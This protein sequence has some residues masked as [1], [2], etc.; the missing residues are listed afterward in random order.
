MASVQFDFHDLVMIPLTPIHVGGGDEAV[1][2]LEDYRVKD[3]FLERVDILKHILAAP[4]S[5][6]LLRDLERDMDGTFS[7]L[8]NR[9][10]D[11][12]VT[13]RIS[14]SKEVRKE[15]KPPSNASKGHRQGK[16]Y[17]FLRSGGFPTLPGSSLK[18]CL[19]TAWLASCAKKQELNESDIGLGKSGDQSKRLT[20]KAFEMDER[21]TAQD[22]FRDVV[23]NDARLPENATRVDMVS[24]WKF[25]RSRK[26]YEVDPSGKIQLMRERMLAVTDGGVPPLL[27]LRIGLRSA[28]VRTRRRETARKNIDPKRSPRSIFELL[29]ALNEHHAPLWEREM[30]KFF[31]GKDQRLI[32]AHRLFDRI[33]LGGDRPGG[34]LIRIG[35]SAHAEAKSVAGFRKIH[36]SQPRFR[37]KHGEF[38]KEGSTRHVI[39][40][41]GGPSPFGWAVLVQTHVWQDRKNAISWLPRHQSPGSSQGPNHRFREGDRVE[42]TDGSIATLLEG[43][44]AGKT[45]V[46]VE[47][48]G[49]REPVKISEIKG[50]A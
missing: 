5:E 27:P 46:N 30:Q 48:D 49:D 47:I 23:V 10:P 37:G 50:P 40:L 24:S 35:W 38:A 28:Q 25:D 18:G 31:S 22:P 2:G 6:R 33:S 7:K 41:P 1:L 21:E 11:E 32:Q 29:S 20:A 17:A 42:L 16:I 13:E 8:Q 43:V 34:A 26:T 14:I 36:R 39:S 4:N 9:I 45:E 12:E 3:S 15:L 19:R 44:N